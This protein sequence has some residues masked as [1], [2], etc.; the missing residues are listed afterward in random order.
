[1]SS[2]P[3][4]TKYSTVQRDTNQSV[5]DNEKLS[6][7]CYGTVDIILQAIWFHGRSQIQTHSISL[8]SQ[9]WKLQL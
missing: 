6:L 7:K 5:D 2:W 4:T 1:M 3:K 9:F 8:N